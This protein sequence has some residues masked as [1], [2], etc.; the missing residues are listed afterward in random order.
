MAEELNCRIDEGSDGDINEVLLWT[1]VHNHC[2][3]V[4]DT[5]PDYGKDLQIRLCK[6]YLGYVCEGREN[7]SIRKYR[8]DF[9]E[10]YVY[11]TLSDEGFLQLCDRFDNEMVE[12][13]G[14]LLTG[15]T[16]Y[17]SLKGYVEN[18]QRV[19]HKRPRTK[20]KWVYLRVT[21]ER[22]RY[23]YFDA[24][25]NAFRLD[26]DDWDVKILRKMENGNVELQK[27]TEY[28]ASIFDRHYYD[29]S[30][31]EEEI[32]YALAVSP[33][34]SYTTDGFGVLPAARNC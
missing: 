15:E 33:S 22:D 1:I 29:C 28:E 21:S 31:I 3:R 23:K 27:P 14:E 2:K 26:V 17:Y 18:L 9:E 30:V 8:E 11:N 6:A 20:H 19:T 13:S 12:H 32:A 24:C 7:E 4:M 16:G 10:Y 5:N 25:D 34:L